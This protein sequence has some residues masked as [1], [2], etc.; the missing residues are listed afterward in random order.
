MIGAACAILAARTVSAQSLSR[1]LS[2]VDRVV[3]KS[4]PSTRLR[5]SF[6]YTTPLLHPPACLFSRCIR[7]RELQK[8]I[9]YP[10]V[11]SGSVQ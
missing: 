5:Q 2:P 6:S 8:T 3:A 1:S 9:Q 11:G 4:S 7:H 10:E